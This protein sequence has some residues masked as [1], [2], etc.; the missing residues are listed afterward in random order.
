MIH[1]VALCPLCRSLKNTLY[2]CDIFGFLFRTVIIVC[3]PPP[4]LSRKR[5]KVYRES[6]RTAARKYARRFMN[7]HRS[8]CIRGYAT[9]YAARLSMC[10][11]RL[12]L[13]VGARVSSRMTRQLHETYDN[14]YRCHHS[15]G[16]AKTKIHSSNNAFVTVIIEYIFTVFSFFIFSRFLVIK[17]SR[18]ILERLLNR[19]HAHTHRYRI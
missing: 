19:T 18:D 6:R 5:C 2:Q 16:K 17:C 9:R 15:D 4:P 8:R 1:C 3:L 7:M 10:P 12:R 11:L 13:N 14:Y